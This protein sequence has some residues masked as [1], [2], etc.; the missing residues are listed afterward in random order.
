MDYL[1]EKLFGTAQ[2][3]NCIRDYNLDIANYRFTFRAGYSNPDYFVSQLNYICFKDA[4]RVF[5]IMTLP[6]KIRCSECELLSFDEAR[7]ESDP[8]Y[9]RNEVRKLQEVYTV[10]ESD[11]FNFKRVV[12]NRMSV[13]VIESVSLFHFTENGCKINALYLRMYQFIKRS[14]AELEKTL[15]MLEN[16]QAWDQELLKTYRTEVEQNIQLLEKIVTLENTLAQ[17]TSGHNKKSVG[18]AIVPNKKFEGISIPSLNKNYNIK[19]R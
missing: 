17:T 6:Q 18:K 19:N 12:K 13:S 5:S 16:F 4:E 14:Y 9:M 11:Y 15:V 7:I 8:V 2:K 10:I 3:R 1:V